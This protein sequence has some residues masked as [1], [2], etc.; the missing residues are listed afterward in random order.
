[1]QEDSHGLVALSL[2]YSD[3]GV[4]GLFV[5]RLQLFDLAKHV[6]AENYSAE[7]DILAVEEGQR[8]THRNVELR[9][10]GVLDPAAFAHA[11]QS[12]LSVLDMKRLVSELSIVN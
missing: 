9:F 10:I 1:M 5:D 3:D 11:Q 6:H 2:G 12:N 8:C 4:C 7:N